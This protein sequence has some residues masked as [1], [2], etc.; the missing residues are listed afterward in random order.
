L[1]F[2]RYQKIIS[3]RRSANDSL[4]YRYFELRDHAKLEFVINRIESNPAIS[5]SVLDEKSY[6]D[7]RGVKTL[8][9]HFNWLEKCFRQ[10]FLNLFYEV[11]TLEN[12]DFKQW[13][14]DFGERIIT[15]EMM[16]PRTEIDRLD[17]DASHK[18]HISS[19][20]TT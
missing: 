5:R 19:F 20:S 18:D 11:N 12:T 3:A 10:E 4:F 2:Y 1:A 17:L 13:I 16:Q 8:I 9:Y 14:F 15:Y 7:V 6:V